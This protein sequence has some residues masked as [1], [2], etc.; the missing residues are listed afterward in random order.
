MPPTANS[1]TARTRRF[2]L[3]RL[4]ALPYRVLAL[5]ARER[6]PRRFE[7]LSRAATA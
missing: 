2:R 6:E 3:P 7:T 5:A 4:I 1:A